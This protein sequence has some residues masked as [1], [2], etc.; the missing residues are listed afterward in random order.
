VY[1]AV[2]LNSDRVAGLNAVAVEL[3][4][5]FKRPRKSAQPNAANA[6]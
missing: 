3:G 2:K 1:G 6:A 5:F 4:T